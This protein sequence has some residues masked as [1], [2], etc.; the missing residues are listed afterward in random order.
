MKY[1]FQTHEGVAT[2]KV[3]VDFYYRDCALES[4]RMVKKLKKKHLKVNSFGKMRVYLAAQVLSHSV[5]KA[6]GTLCSLGIYPPEHMATSNFVEMFDCLFNVFNGTLI[7]SSAKYRHP[8]TLD[9]SHHQ[10]L[11]TAL[12]WL[13]NLRYALKPSKLMH[14]KN[15]PCMSGWIHNIIALKQFLPTILGVEPGVEYIVTNRLNQDA[16]ENLFSVIRGKGSHHDNP[17]PQQFRYRLRQVMVDKILIPSKVS[18]CQDDVDSFLVNLT[19]DRAS[20]IG[21]QQHLTMPHATE[22]LQ[23]MNLLKSCAASDLIHLE[24]AVA[25]VSGWILKKVYPLV[26]NECLVKLEFYPQKG[27][28]TPLQLTLIEMKQYEDCIHGGLKR[29]SFHLF[30]TVKS[31]EQDFLNEV[32][33]RMKDK[34]IRKTFSQQLL[35]SVIMKEL[36]GEDCSC[37]TVHLVIQCFISVRLHHEIRMMNET[38]AEEKIA[39][40]KIKKNRKLMK[41]SHQ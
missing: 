22:P 3:I 19:Q 4:F 21:T 34:N 23:M 18:N 15:L 32:K 1:D 17:D 14:A 37:P 24:N 5:A 40:H 25:Y 38:I 20:T 8:I 29:P 16:I 7:S 6:I 31:F 35:N 10:F 13:E 11:D 36:K 33:M 28:A 30:K 2:W 12:N 27:Q 39:K 26:C 41:V 9:S